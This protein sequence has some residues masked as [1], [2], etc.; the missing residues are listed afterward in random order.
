MRMTIKRIDTNARL[1]KVVVHNGLAY[2]AGQVAD[3]LDAPVDVQTRETLAKIDALL[4]GVGSD[5]TRILS[6]Q[7]W[8][9]DMAQAPQMNAVWEAWMPQG[10]APA[11]ATVG[12]PLATPRHLIEIKVVA[13]VG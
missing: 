5:K 8:L 6:A 1:S 7:I 3:T 11:R 2:L 4:Q 12:A 10:H 13:T 9:A